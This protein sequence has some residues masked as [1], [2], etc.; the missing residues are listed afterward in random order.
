MAGLAV[1]G[2]D[3]LTY[4][5]LLPATAIPGLVRMS[6]LWCLPLLTASVTLSQIVWCAEVRLTVHPALQWLGKLVVI[7][8]ALYLC[9]HTLPLD[10]SPRNLLWPA[11][12]VQTGFFA[13]GIGLAGLSPLTGPVLMHRVRWWLPGLALGN[14]VTVSTAFFVFLP[15]FRKLYG[16]PLVPGYG[17]YLTLVSALCLVGLGVRPGNWMWPKWFKTGYGKTAAA[18]VKKG[19]KQMQTDTSADNQ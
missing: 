11:N 13:L 12:M 16:Q 18:R 9:L 1:L 8:L 17:V 14:L 7:A 6:W 19:A 15:F 10:W 5:K 3:F 4:I 2:V